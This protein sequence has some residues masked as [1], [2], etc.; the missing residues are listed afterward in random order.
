MSLIHKGIKIASTNIVGDTLPIGSQVPFGSLTIPDNWLLCD[1]SAISRVDYSEL[2]AV[3]GTS[4]GAGNGTTTF[5]L[6]NKKG[7]TSVGYDASQTEFNT[8]GKTG[9]HKLLQAHT[10]PVYQTPADGAV[11]YIDGVQR[12][13]YDVAPIAQANTYVGNT[14]STGGGNAQ[15]LQPYET[16]V[17]I[18]KAKQ[19]AGVVATVIDTLDSTSP[20]NALS[21]NMG[22]VLKEKIEGTVLYDNATGT[23]GNVTL[24]E[25]SANFSYLEI[26]YKDE[27]SNYSSVKVYSPNGKKISLQT[28]K[29]ATGSIQFYMKLVT[30][31]G[32]TISS[33][34]ADGYTQIFNAGS[35]AGYNNSLNYILITR[36]VG[37]K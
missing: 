3:I 26:F 36:V 17:W 29:C 4:Y 16:D 11:T 23:T 8:L 14:Q 35:S 37:Y 30:I 9:G 24:S 21:S 33:G 22:R 2:F 6:P 31:S 1:G 12:F 34:T 5:N 19:S 13:K 15:N 32:T 18:I 7:R 27:S 28:M 10:H 25:T 20:T